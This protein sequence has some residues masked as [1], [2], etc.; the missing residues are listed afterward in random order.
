[1]VAVLVFLEMVALAGLVRAFAPFAA[2]ASG[3]ARRSLLRWSIAGVGVW[4]ATFVLAGYAFADSLGR[5]LQAGGNVA[6][7][8]AGAVAIT[9]LLR[10]RAAPSTRTRFA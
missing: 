2:G 4:G 8:L 9:Y 10:R 3:M 6:L 1:V 7:A 5:S